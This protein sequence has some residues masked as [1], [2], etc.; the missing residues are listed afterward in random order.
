MIKIFK[1]DYLSFFFCETAA[2]GRV[3]IVITKNHLNSGAWK[4]TE[5]FGPFTV[6]LYHFHGEN[7]C[8]P[9]YFISAL[10]TSRI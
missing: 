3:F 6:D 8:Y 1:S 4:V 5:I 10:R 9:S 2:E 7:L